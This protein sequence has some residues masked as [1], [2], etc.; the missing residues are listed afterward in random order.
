MS[1][2]SFTL[3]LEET[4]SKDSDLAFGSSTSGF[5]IAIGALALSKLE[6]ACGKS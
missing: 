6:A 3:L 2:A 1:T 5:L 4:G